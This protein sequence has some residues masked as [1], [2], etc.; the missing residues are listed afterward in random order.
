MP[1]STRQYLNAFFAE[2]FF[3][4]AALEA[5]LVTYVNDPTASAK[6]FDASSIPKISRA[7]AAQDVAR[8][9][10]SISYSG[11]YP[12]IRISGPSTLDI[13]GVPASKRVSSTPPPTAAETQSA[14]A[15][16][17]ADVPE[18]A[19]YGPVLNSSS[20]PIQLTESETEYQVTCVK[21][22]FQEHIVFQ[23]RLDQLIFEYSILISVFAVQC[24]EYIAR[25]CPGASVC[26]HAASSR[27]RLD[28]GFHHADSFALCVYFAQHCLRI[29]HSRFA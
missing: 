19:E 6:A 13:I 3:S 7:Q 25:H 29:L 16:Q 9:F 28:G 20:K 5:K 12:D 27:H 14:Y 15:T 23:V 2:S 17:L 24:I 26:F 11:R 22:I 21:H 8:E 1:V 10:N 4:L 18:L